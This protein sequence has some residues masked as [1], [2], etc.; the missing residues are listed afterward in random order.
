[1]KKPTLLRR[2]AK[3]RGGFTL[4]ETIVSIALL[5]I[6]SI[7][8]AEILI[9]SLIGNRNTQTHMRQSVQ[10]GGAMAAD[11]ATTSTNGTGTITARQSNSTATITFSN[12]TTAS[13]NGKVTDGTITDSAGD[14]ASVYKSFQP[15]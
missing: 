8:L 13:V 7:T 4:I 2:A 1:M 10:L 11:S 5:A 12:G 14:T 9:S 15:S 6:A 3:A